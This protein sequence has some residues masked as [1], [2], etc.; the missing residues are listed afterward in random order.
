MIIDGLWLKGYV[1]LYRGHIYNFSDADAVE[2]TR[3]VPD[4]SHDV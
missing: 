3:P 2:A 4:F 1:G